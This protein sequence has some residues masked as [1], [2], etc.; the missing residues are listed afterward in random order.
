MTL[1]RILIS[2]NQIIGK[3]VIGAYYSILKAI[4]FP[5]YF[6]HSSNIIVNYRFYTLPLHQHKLHT[7]QTATDLDF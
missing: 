3:S 6:L 1:F 4:I 2:A 7:Q 5:A